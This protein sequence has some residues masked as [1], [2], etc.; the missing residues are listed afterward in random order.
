MNDDIKQK[1]LTITILGMPNA[2][3]STLLNKLVGQKISI[4]TPK[5]QTTR[6]TITGI[7]TCGLTQLVFIDTPGVFQPRKSLEKAMVRC[8]W[9]SVAGA[10]LILLIIDVTKK[11][12][13][14]VLLIIERLVLRKLKFFII[15]NKIDYK[16]NL[17]SL[18]INNIQKMS[19][20][21]NILETSAQKG[22]GVK[23]LLDQMLA[24]A[25]TR[26]WMYNKED[27]TT[28]STKFMTQEITRE[29]LFLTLHEELPYN[30][31][32]ETEK[33]ES[34]NDNSIK[35]HQVI[36]VNKVNHKTIILGK[37][38]TKIKTISQNARIAIQETFGFKVHLF[39]FVKIKPG[40]DQDPTFYE[41]I[42]LKFVK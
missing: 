7:L 24:I 26:P 8:A 36:I 25:P 11:L 14:K 20:N 13:D 12:D 33:W 40:W 28:V 30:I 5:V 3:K 9:S 34:L 17:K 31:T 32:V 21:T 4:V 41:N 38:G 1:T 15:L 37:A 27:I 6:S 42:G 19:L 35:I 22:T 2:G 23:E 16:K 29:Q 39:L 18:Y 10:D